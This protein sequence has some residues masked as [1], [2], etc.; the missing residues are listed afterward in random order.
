MLLQSLDAGE[1]L[2]GDVLGIRPDPSDPTCLELNLETT[3]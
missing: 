1:A 3:E 2:G